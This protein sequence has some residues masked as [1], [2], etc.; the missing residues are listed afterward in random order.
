MSCFVY[1]CP[2]ILIV[3]CCKFDEKH[4]KYCYNI[5]SG[6]DRKED[7]DKEHGGK[8]IKSD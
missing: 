8:L 7:L 1:I 3:F 4:C 5:Y 6:I 2:K